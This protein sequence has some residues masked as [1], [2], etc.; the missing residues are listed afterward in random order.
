MINNWFPIFT[1]QYFRP[2][3]RPLSCLPAPVCYTSQAFATL[4]L[5]SSLV[6]L[7]LDSTSQIVSHL[8]I[9]W[10]HASLEQ[11]PWLSLPHSFSLR[12]HDLRFYLCLFSPLEC[13]LDSIYS[14]PAVEGP[15]LT[16]SL[17]LPRIPVLPWPSEVIAPPWFA[18]GPQAATRLIHRTEGFKSHAP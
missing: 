12:A 15:K 11:F 1:T 4:P 7:I 18:S 13:D 14:C 16:F 5:F 2:S 8:P 6:S 3:P 17:W 10:L 9:F